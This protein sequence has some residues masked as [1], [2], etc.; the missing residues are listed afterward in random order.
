ME[1]ARDRRKR[2]MVKNRKGKRIASHGMRASHEKPMKAGGFF[3]PKVEP[4][5][6]VDLRK[7]CSPVENQSQSNSCCANA[8]VGAYEYLCCRAAAESG[9]TPGDVSRLFVYYV[10]RL[11]DKQR[12]RDSSP[13]ADEGMTIAGAIDALSMK[14]AC[15]KSSWEFDLSN[16]NVKPPPEAFDEAMHY[17]VSRAESV[18]VDVTAMKACLAA[19]FPILFGLKLTAKFFHPGKSGRVAVPD[20]N[21]PKSAE[22]GL[23][24][25][26][27]VGYSDRI[28]SFIVRN[29]WG[30][31]WGDGGYCYIPYAYAGNEQFNFCGQYVIYSLTDT[32]FTP[33][34]AD[35]DKI[36]PEPADDESDAGGE[37]EVEDEDIDEAEEVVDH[38]EADDMFD[39][40][41]EAR[42]AFNRFDIDGNGT[43]NTKEL[44]KAL[45]LTGTFMKRKKVRKLIKKYDEDGSGSLSFEEF[46]KL[47]GV[48][49]VDRGG[50]PSD[51]D[52]DED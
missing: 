44:F 46:I 27:I 7:W 16:V 42:R 49:P 18:P 3:S 25:M 4:P 12:Y 35:E 52:D 37:I 15:L 33:E 48:I 24:A 10:G 26:L 47:P 34:A 28:E 31:D 14:G 1:F 29:S 23:H 17:K 19:G 9:D 43:L 8:A 2:R 32:D 50:T 22:H 6:C 39:P 5:S 36:A 30:E 21:D 51:H 40:I 20:P 38:E 41:A 13:I 11:R 45:L